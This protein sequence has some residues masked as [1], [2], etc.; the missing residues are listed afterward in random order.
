V[1][2]AGIEGYEFSA[3]ILAWGADQAAAG[4]MQGTGA[5]GPLEAFGLDAVEQGCR[6][7]GVTRVGDSG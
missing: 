1:H 3:G 5:L 6:E 4:R 7:A 2:L